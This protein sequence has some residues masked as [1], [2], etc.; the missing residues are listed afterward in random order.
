[1]PLGPSDRNSLQKVTTSVCSNICNA[2]TVTHTKRIYRN[3]LRKETSFVYY[4]SLVLIQISPNKLIHELAKN[5][6]T[7]STSQLSVIFMNRQTLFQTQKKSLPSKRISWFLTI[8][9][10]RSRT[11]VKHIT[12]VEGMQIVIVCIWVKIISNCLVKQ[13]EKIQISFVCFPKTRKILITFLTT[14][15]LK[16]W[17]KNSSKSCVRLHSRSHTILLWL[18]WPHQRTLENTDLDLTTFIL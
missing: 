4:T 18:I 1:M 7:N 3:L 11:S 17:R 10:F 2:T 14:T 16:T 9:C 8:S 5:Q 6:K 12:F 13:F 15:C